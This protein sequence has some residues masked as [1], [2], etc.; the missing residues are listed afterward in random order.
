MNLGTF[1]FVKNE[2][3][4]SDSLKNTLDSYYY[5]T[6]LPKKFIRVEVLGKTNSASYTGTEINVN[7]NNRNLFRGAELLTFLYLAVPIFSF[8]EQIKEKISIN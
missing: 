2:F 4:P 3:K 6:L 7:W 1:S 8:Q 5:L